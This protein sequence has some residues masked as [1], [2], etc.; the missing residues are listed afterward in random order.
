MR[1][2][3]SILLFIA[4]TILACSNIEKELIIGKWAIDTV[5][6][7]GEKDL[8]NMRDIRFEFLP[9]NK[10]FFQS[11]LNITEAGH[12]S[13]S[14]DLLNTTDTT[15]A[16]T[17]EKSVKITKLTADSLYFIMNNSGKKQN[18]KFVRVK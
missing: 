12:Y 1:F 2:R 13:I 11:T 10:Y 6:G 16:I 7:V 14:G 15:V 17:V 3:L 9:N 5:E 4:I 18:L 8:K